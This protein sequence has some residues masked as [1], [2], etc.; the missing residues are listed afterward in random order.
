[1]SNS[2]SISMQDLDILREIGNIGAGNAATALSMILNKKVWLD[3]PEA[4]LCS[5][6][7]IPEKLGG[8]EEVRTG[9]FFGVKEALKGF[10]FFILEDEDA[11]KLHKVASMGL[12]IDINSVLSEVSNIISGAYVGAIASMI[13]DTV[14]ITPPEIGHDMVGSLIDSIVSVLCNVGNQAVYIKTSMNIEEETIAGYY[15]LMLEQD[16]LMKLLNYFKG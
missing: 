11:D 12:E 9:I 7:E 13:N 1:M 14:D 8:A 2:E 10:I 15:V 5:L 3:V 6:T 4:Q 16:S